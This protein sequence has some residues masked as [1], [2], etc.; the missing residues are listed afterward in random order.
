M[1]FR[2]VMLKSVQ[3][4]KY[5]FLS[6]L[7]ETVIVEYKCEIFTASETRMPRFSLF[8]SKQHLQN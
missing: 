4:F 6:L 7:S 8:N 5:T 3:S 1:A 2:M